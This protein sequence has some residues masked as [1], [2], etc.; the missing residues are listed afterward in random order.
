MG[1]GVDDWVVSIGEWVVGNGEW[2]VGCV[3]LGFGGSL[4]GRVRSI[5][6]CGYGFGSGGVVGF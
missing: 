4:G 5:W 6:V 2:V 1:C 3:G